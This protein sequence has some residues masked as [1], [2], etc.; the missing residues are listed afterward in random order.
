MSENGARDSEHARLHLL[1]SNT[2]EVQSR[3]LSIHHSEQPS[4]AQET[5]LIELDEKLLPFVSEY[6]NA[7][8]HTL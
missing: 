3:G 5:G 6:R 2:E 7:T 8:G 4:T 1:K